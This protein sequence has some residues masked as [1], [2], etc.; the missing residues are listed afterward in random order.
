MIETLQIWATLGSALA[1][2]IFLRAA[3]RKDI[4]LLE[5]RVNKLEDKLE[6]IDEK[7]DQIHIRLTRLEGRFDERGYWEAREWKKTGTEDKN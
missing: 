2:Y 4:S 5:T 6:K 3:S 1:L 7:I